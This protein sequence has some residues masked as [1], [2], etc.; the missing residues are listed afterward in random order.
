MSFTMML[1][2]AQAGAPQWT[3]AIDRHLARMTVPGWLPAALIALC[4]LVAV[5]A[6][7][8][9]ATRQLS[10]A[11]GA[12]LA[13]TGWLV[14][15]GLGDLTSGQATDPNSGPLIVLLAVAVASA[16]QRRAA[17]AVRL[18]DATT[19]VDEPYGSKESVAHL[20]V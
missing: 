12:I 4:V 9:G 16:T 6:L 7:V 18:V 3:A 1:R 19:P 10:I 5:W 14:F 15:Q 8:P 2:S 13:T 17:R 20:Y 11:V